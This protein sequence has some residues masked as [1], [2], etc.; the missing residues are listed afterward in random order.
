MIHSYVYSQTTQN[1]WH[2]YISFVIWEAIENVGNVMANMLKVQS[3][4]EVAR[5]KL[6]ALGTKESS[7]NPSST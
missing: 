4:M 2:L 1:K 6:A 7:E 3:K 5:D